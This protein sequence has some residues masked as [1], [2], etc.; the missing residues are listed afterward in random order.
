MV[1]VSS[2]VGVVTPER[3]ISCIRRYGAVVGGEGCG[4]SM[5]VVGSFLRSL[6]SCLGFELAVVRSAY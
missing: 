6:L 5:V 1:E 3:S 2:A 4:C